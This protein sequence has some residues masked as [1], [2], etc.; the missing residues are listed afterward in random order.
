MLSAAIAYTEKAHVHPRTTQETSRKHEGVLG[1]KEEGTGEGLSSG[2]FPNHL[3]QVLTA[4]VAAVSISSLLK[5]LLETNVV[6]P[7]S[8]TNS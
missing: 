2:F 7:T 5:N 8:R 1:R 6:T 3:N 4:R